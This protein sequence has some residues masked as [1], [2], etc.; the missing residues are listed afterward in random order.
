M[1]TLFSALVSFLYEFCL[2]HA[3]HPTCN[4]AAAMSAPIY[5]GVNAPVVFQSWLFPRCFG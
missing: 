1:F 5:H 2:Q 3:T 4:S